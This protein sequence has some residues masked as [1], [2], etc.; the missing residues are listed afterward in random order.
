M[1]PFSTNYYMLAGI[2]ICIAFIIE[3]LGFTRFG[4]YPYSY[5]IPVMKYKYEISDSHAIPDTNEQLTFIENT[6][7]DSENYTTKTNRNTGEVYIR[8]RSKF[9]SFTK[10]IF[11]VCGTISHTNQS[12]TIRIGLVFWMFLIYIAI[13]FWIFGG[14]TFDI[15]W[16]VFVC[17]FYLGA[18]F[19]EYRKLQKHLI[20][21][22]T[23]AKNVK[24]RGQ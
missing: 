11:F 23:I 20:N 16:I 8:K 6:I 7:R 15:I 5:G 13:S 3:F 19:A 9:L 14:F 24:P 1:A 22:L 18:M 10:W 12:V 17:S 4:K 2:P 21:H